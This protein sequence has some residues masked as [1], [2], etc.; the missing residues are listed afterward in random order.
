M[1]IKLIAERI[2]KHY[3]SDLTNSRSRSCNREYQSLYPHNQN[4]LKTDKLLSNTL[5]KNRYLIEKQENENTDSQI[6][7]DFL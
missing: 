5:N 6:Q 4:N 3:D 2:N 7:G 1:N